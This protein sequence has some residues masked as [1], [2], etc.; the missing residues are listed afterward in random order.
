MHLPT[1][2]IVTL[3]L[4]STSLLA[5]SFDNCPLWHGQRTKK[6]EALM[7]GMKQIFSGYENLDCPKESKAVIDRLSQIPNFQSLLANKPNTNM[8]EQS[9]VFFS[10]QVDNYRAFVLAMADCRP[11]D[12]SSTGFYVSEMLRVVGLLAQYGPGG[13]V[14]QSGIAA[15]MNFVGDVTSRLFRKDS[16]FTFPAKMETDSLYDIACLD[17]EIYNENTGCGAPAP[18]LPF[19]KHY[20][21]DLPSMV[22][23]AGRTGN[24]GVAGISAVTETWK[25]I[26]ELQ[27]KDENIINDPRYHALLKKYHKFLTSY[28]I[29]PDGTQPVFMK[30]HLRKVAQYLTNEASYLTHAG[31]DNADDFRLR[32]VGDQILEIMKMDDEVAKAHAMAIKTRSAEDAEKYDVAEQ[33][34]LKALRGQALSNF[35]NALLYFWEDSDHDPRKIGKLAWSDFKKAVA[36][37]PSDLYE[38][39][40]KLR[41]GLDPASLDT[42]GHSGNGPAASTLDRTKR[43]LR[44]TFNTIHPEVQKLIEAQIIRLNSKY[45]RFLLNPNRNWDEDEPDRKIL[46]NTRTYIRGKFTTLGEKLRGED[47]KADPKLLLKDRFLYEVLLPYMDLCTRLVMATTNVRSMCKVFEC[48]GR[49]HGFPLPIATSDPENPILAQMQCERWTKEYT[50]TKE[51]AMLQNFQDSPKHDVCDDAKQPLPNLP[52]DIGQPSQDHSR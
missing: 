14:A 18:G 50:D 41:Y 23:G 20:D 19:T 11:K 46:P 17:G 12:N 31:G 32:R 47:G 45:K 52:P 25:A 49:P 38:Q 16:K 27:G 36:D 33:K 42:M 24:L 1:L 10:D 40:S 30:D 26:R 22:Y 4:H 37:E 13:P 51:A 48:G 15:G 29:P 3:L 7:L 35:S 6:A 43:D 34:L 21:P 44:V 9:A 8:G 2:I 39:K 5:T 28:V